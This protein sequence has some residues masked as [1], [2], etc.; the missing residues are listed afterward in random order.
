[1]VKEVKKLFIPKPVRP[2]PFGETKPEVSTEIQ[3]KID[4]F[5]LL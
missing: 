5:K 4:K 2:K 3:K 1:M